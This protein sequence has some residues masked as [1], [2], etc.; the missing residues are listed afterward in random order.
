MYLKKLADLRHTLAF[1]LTL[2][3]A[4]IFTVSTGVAFFLFYLQITTFMRARTDQDL[5]NQARKI[6]SVFLCMSISLFIIYN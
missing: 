4:L 1:R 2:W 5:L 6:S 3:Y